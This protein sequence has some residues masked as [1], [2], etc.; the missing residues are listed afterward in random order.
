MPF[1]P[2]GCSASGLHGCP[3]NWL[4][5]SW[6]S[7]PQGHGATWSPVWVPTLLNWDHS[8]CLG[9]Q[10]W[11]ELAGVAYRTHRVGRLVPTGMAF[12]FHRMQEEDRR[13]P[14]MPSTWLNC[15]KRYV[16]LGSAF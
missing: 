3:L 2:S 15:R 10:D 4:G 14:Q 12:I 7:L 11:D 13:A 1:K 8:P 6:A 5:P 9:P 16:L